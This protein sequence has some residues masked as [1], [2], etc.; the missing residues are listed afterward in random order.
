M[1]CS[2][3]WVYL[4]L[5]LGLKVDPCNRECQAA[6]SVLRVGSHVTCF[7]ATLFNFIGMHKQK[8][9]DK[10]NLG[11]SPRKILISL[12]LNIRKCKGAPPT[13]WWIPSCDADGFSSVYSFLTSWRCLNRH[14]C[15]S[16]L[17][18][19]SNQCVYTTDISQ[20]EYIG[21]W[22]SWHFLYTESFGSS[23]QSCQPWNVFPFLFHFLME[24]ILS[25]GL[26]DASKRGVLAKGSEGIVQSFPECVPRV[27]ISW[28]VM[29][30]VQG[31]IHG[32]ICLGNTGL[33]KVNSFVFK[34]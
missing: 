25:L 19:I 3:R 17:G 21:L 11:T 28:N 4:G 29:S 34:V 27:L 13:K 5:I 33:S 15:A 22:P 20:A 26:G 16:F 32:Q 8:L 24:W 6:G 2:V 12:P 10:V 9:A 7:F 18:E 31:R 14:S 30:S 1:L 23:I